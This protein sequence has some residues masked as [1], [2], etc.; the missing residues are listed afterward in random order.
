MDVVLINR[1]DNLIMPILP[2]P[3]CEIARELTQLADIHPHICVL[4]YAQ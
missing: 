4:Q 3:L 2:K 1:W